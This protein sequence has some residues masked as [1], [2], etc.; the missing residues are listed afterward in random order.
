MG[1]IFWALGAVDQAKV[2]F[3]KV[4]SIRTDI[5]TIHNN[6]AA[7]YIKRGDFKKAAAHLKKLISLQP[8]NM[9]AQKLLQFSIGQ[10][11]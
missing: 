6:L 7:I 3:E 2:S 11:R 10:I 1:T 4:L 5:P 9:N 8:E